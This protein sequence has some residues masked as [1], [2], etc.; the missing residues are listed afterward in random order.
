METEQGIVNTVKLT[1]FSGVSW[2]S[3]LTILAWPSD[4]LHTRWVL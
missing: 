4:V 1:L 2:L 3:W